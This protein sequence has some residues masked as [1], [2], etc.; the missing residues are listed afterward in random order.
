MDA[1]ASM[2]HRVRILSHERRDFY[3]MNHMKS[4]G[5]WMAAVFLGVLLFGA[6]LPA[7]AAPS[8]DPM[9]YEG[10][11]VIAGQTFN[12]SIVLAWIAKLL[13]DEYT[14]L[15]TEIN[16]EFA[17]SSV[18]HQGM[19]GEEIDVY[20]T[21]TGTQLTGILRYEEEDL[22][23]LNTPEKAYEAVK[24]GYEKN[25]RMT[26]AKPLGFSN[27]YAMAVRRADAEK[28]GLEKASDLAKVASEWLLGSDENFDT[29][30]DGYPG[31][32]ETYGIEFKEALPMQYSIMYK[33]IEGEEV[34]AIA[35]YTTD[36]RIKK[37]DLVTLKDDKHFFPD[38]SACY[39]IDMDTLEKYPAL[40]N[41]VEKV[42]GTIDEPTMA[43]MNWR[44][45]DGEEPE[46]IARDFLKERGLIK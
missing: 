39:V 43:G 40:L 37:L 33:A 11:V 14:G 32:S 2:E 17:A 3:M 46:D 22:K 24:E 4:V 27:T 42:S 6:A 9:D 18:L 13:I 1:G 19:V 38:Y 12:E 10:E 8:E 16:T 21:W 5:M 34:Q 20:P 36:S 26:W 45:D 29:R 25:F 35:A 7:V 23:K 15:E 28:Y 31:W 41:V 30:P 44:F